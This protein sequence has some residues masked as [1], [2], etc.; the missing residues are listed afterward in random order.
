[1]LRDLSQQFIGPQAAS[2]IRA[3]A[4][5]AKMFQPQTPEQESNQSQRLQAA[6]D[7]QDDK[8]VFKDPYQQHLDL[9]RATYGAQFANKETLLRE[10]EELLRQRGEEQAGRA[11]QNRLQ[12]EQEKANLKA[13]GDVLR[14]AST[15]AA[16]QGFPVPNA[17][18]LQQAAE[19][20]ASEQ[21]LN[22]DLLKARIGLAGARTG[23][24]G[25]QEQK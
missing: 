25:A 1:K 14:R 4:T 19:Q 10:R 9:L 5:M 8:I 20:I 3:G 2:N 13:H 7:L 22:V 17:D 18:H 6:R 15:I 23:L 11:L 24:A 12:I 21:G 16:S